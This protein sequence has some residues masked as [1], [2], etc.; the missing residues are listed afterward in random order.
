M[1]CCKCCF[2]NKD[3]G[4]GEQGKCCCGGSSGTGC[5]ASQY[6][7][8]GTCQSTPCT[9]ACCD[10]TF[11]CTQAA[12][13]ATCTEDGGIW[14]GLGVSCDPNPCECVENSDCSESE[15]Y[16]CTAQ[17]Q[18]TRCVNCGSCSSITPNPSED[19]PF[20][21]TG[22]ISGC[23][24]SQDIVTPC[25]C[26]GSN[27]YIG[28]CGLSPFAEH[29][30]EEYYDCPCAMLQTYCERVT[31]NGS[32]G[33]ECVKESFHTAYRDFIYLFDLDTCKWVK[34]K[35]L[36]GSISHT[37]CTN[38]DSEAEACQDVDCPEEAFCTP[39]D[40]GTFDG[41]ECNEFP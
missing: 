10:A 3:C 1:A 14:L 19:C 37:T 28:S 12:D 16:C 7:C 31:S 33:C 20:T 26:S 38:E 25:G 24:G 5:T 27:P 29:V 35:E 40:C 13:E 36:A 9:G 41:C 32:T 2:G 6:C 11:G 8:S 30:A 18:S 4:E 15:P 23:I 21:D 39:P 34:Y 17:C 22:A